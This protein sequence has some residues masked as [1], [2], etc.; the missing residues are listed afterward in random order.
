MTGDG[1]QG[2][3]PGA[4]GGDGRAAP[5]R[6]ARIQDVADRA[7]VSPALVSRLL[8]G[9]PRLTV[10][11]QTRQH[12]LAAVDEL[13][14]VARSAAASLRRNRADAIG[15]VLDSVTNPVF[16]D[17]VHGA[18]G[19]ATEL[20]CG[21]LLLD[22]QEVVRAPGFLT[23]VVRSRRVDGLLLQGGY[24]PAADVLARFAAEVPSVV[25]NAP[26]GDAASGV[27]LQDDRAARLATEHLVGL[28]HRRIGFVA[29]APGHASDTRR[30][31]WQEALRAAGLAPGPVVGAGWRAEDGRAALLPPA[32][33]GVTAYVVASAVVA[34]GV[35]SAL[36]DQGV[37]V[38]EDVS[39]VAVHDPWFAAHLTPA[40]T[41][42]ALPLAELGRR[43]V[44]RLMAHLE[45]GTPAQEVVTDPAPRLVVRAST[46]T[47]SARG[48]SA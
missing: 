32:S 37:R 31:G 27:V 16:T 34:L 29:G 9:D 15:L 42:V 38:P 13:G 8:N 41:T 20:G 6:P 14:Y 24:G 30:R 4:R 22:A 35:L 5:R 1:A 7:G 47:P 21:L 19:A 12:V 46:R 28:G 23:D 33:R 44:L 3:I 18:Q 17:L 43:A 40:L 45:S 26:G 25:V 36:A 10:R 11:P 39:V 48:P 2:A